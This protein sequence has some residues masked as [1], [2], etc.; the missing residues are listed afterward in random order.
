M[1]FPHAIF[2]GQE[3]ICQNLKQY[4]HGNGTIHGGRVVYE[5]LFD[6]SDLPNQ[7]LVSCTLQVIVL[8]P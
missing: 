8:T 5:N 6:K 3:N 1:H 7:P 2:L 4:G